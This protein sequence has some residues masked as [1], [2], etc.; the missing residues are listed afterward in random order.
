M[1]CR[2]ER[3]YVVVAGLVEKGVKH[4]VKVNPGT[5]QVYWGQ[6]VSLYGLNL[7]LRKGIK[8]QRLDLLNSVLREAMKLQVPWLGICLTY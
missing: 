4:S 8:V 6:I 2:V 3:R 7:S 5:S 1:K